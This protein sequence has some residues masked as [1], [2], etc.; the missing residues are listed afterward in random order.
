[1]LPEQ[2]YVSEWLG[3]LSADNCITNLELA[4]NKQKTV[5][6]EHTVWDEATQ[7]NINQ[8]AVCYHPLITYCS[9]K[10]YAKKT[11]TDKKEFQGYA[12]HFFRMYFI[13]LSKVK[14]T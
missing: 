10:S 6:S 8:P 11:V 12:I 4:H 3:M 2:Q 14:Q 13:V 9:A 5:A 1:M 7:A